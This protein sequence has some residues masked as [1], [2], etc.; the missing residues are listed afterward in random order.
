LFPLNVV[1]VEVAAMVE[2]EVMV[3]DEDGDGVMDVLLPPK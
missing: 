3:E 2:E 1:A